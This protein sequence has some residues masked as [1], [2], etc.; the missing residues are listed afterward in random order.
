MRP[1]PSSP[2]DGATVVACVTAAPRRAVPCE[3]PASTSPSRSSEASVP[4]GRKSSMN[5]Y[6]AFMPAASGW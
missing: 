2:I 4:A 6:A 1:A 5:G 3:P